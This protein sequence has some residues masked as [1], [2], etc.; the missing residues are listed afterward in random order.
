MYEF[1]II[2]ISMLST[3]VYGNNKLITIISPLAML[4]HVLYL[5]QCTCV[6]PNYVKQKAV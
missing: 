4:D 6:H 2:A 3:N 5:G 1:V